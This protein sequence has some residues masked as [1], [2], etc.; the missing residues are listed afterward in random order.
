[1]TGKI[2]VLIFAWAVIVT[3]GVPTIIIAHSWKAPKEASERQNPTPKN[4]TPL[5][6]VKHC[7]GNTVRP[8]TVKTGR[9]MAP[10]QRN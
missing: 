7:T 1:M 2:L 5:K 9:V 10:W 4:R 8:V 3:I 6:E